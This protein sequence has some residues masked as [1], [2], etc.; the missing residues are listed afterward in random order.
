MELSPRFARAIA[1]DPSDPMIRLAMDTHAEHTKISFRQGV[2][3]DLSFLPG[4]SVDM[5]VA[6][7]A[8]HW[9]KY[10]KVWPELSRVVK[11][12]GKLAFWGYKDNIII[13]HPEANKIFDRFCYGEADVAPGL[14]GLNQYWER[15]GRD[16][17]RGLLADVKPPESE[18]DKI[19]RITYNVDK[20]TTEIA[21]PETA[22]MRKKL[23][24]GHFEAYT[25]TFTSY[26]AW[27]DAHP[28][29]KSRAEG[30][31]GDIVDLLFDQILETEPAW[32]EQGDRW[33]DIEVESVWGTYILLATRK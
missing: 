32:K 26:R 8:A 5:A 9:F 20:D 30:G 2:A 13:G 15:S 11:P 24:L 4:H 6:G 21:G 25:R 19:K 7:Q 18:W 10:P 16:L 31:E 28:D 22:W 23:K 1:I 14:E 3:E 27:M 17:L 12:G 33:R 29:K